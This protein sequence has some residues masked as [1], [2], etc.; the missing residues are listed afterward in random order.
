MESEKHHVAAER[1]GHARTIPGKPQPRGET[2]NNKNDLILDVRA[3]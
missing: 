1:E 3:S 2:Q